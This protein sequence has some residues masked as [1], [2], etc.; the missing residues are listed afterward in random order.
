MARLNLSLLG[1]PQIELDGHPVIT[2]RRKAIAL[3]TYLAVT[4]TIHSR[5]SLAALFWPESDQSRALAYLRRTLWEINQ[6][7][8]D[9][10]LSIDRNTVTLFPGVDSWLDVYEFNDL[11]AGNKR[12][13]WETAVSLYRGDFLAGFTLRDTPDFDEWHYYQMEQL[14]QTMTA[15]LA[16][17][18]TRLAAQ[19]AWETAVP[20]AHR[21][22][23]LDPLHE[24]A[25][26]H[27]MQL[28]AQ[29]NQKAA[30]IRQ[31][32]ICTRTLAEELNVSP[33]EETTALYERIRA[34]H[35]PGDVHGEQNDRGIE[36]SGNKDQATLSAH[37]TPGRNLPTQSTPFVGRQAELNDLRSL[38]VDSMVRLLSL[39]GPGGSG[40]TRLALQIAAQEQDT[41]ADGVY[42][43]PLAA[44]NSPDNLI[45]AIAKSLRLSFFKEG[46]PPQ[47]QL[48]DYL[49]ARHLLLIL[50]NYE[51]LLVDDSGAAQV[52]EI[53]TAAPDVKVL[54]TS[55]L[56]LSLQAEHL[57]M[58]QGMRVPD[59]QA[60][61]DW[62]HTEQTITDFIVPYSAI[63]LFV[64]AA[65]RA[66]PTFVLSADTLTIVARICR[67]LDG[68]PLAI[69]LAAAW[70]S[71]L[72]LA[73]IE[74]E[75]GH[76]LDFLATDIHDVPERQRSIRAV[77]NYS[78]M[79]LTEPEKAVL[80]QLTIFQGGFTREAAQ[81]VANASL[82]M[83][84]AMMH[85]SLIKRE[86]DG[87]F[88]MH[89]LLRQYAAEK[90]QDD[91]EVWITVR[92]R[93]STFY[94]DL[95]RREGRYMQS[96]AQRAGFDAVEQ[97]IENVR[98]AWLWAIVQ[99]QYEAVLPTLD[100]LV[101][102][103]MVRATLI[104]G[105]ADLFDMVLGDLETVVTTHTI[106]PGQPTPAHLLYV[107]ILA[108][109]AW[110]TSDDYA[111][112]IPVALSSKAL[113]LTEKWN[114]ADQIGLPLT[115]VATVYAYRVDK[116]AGI[117]WGYRSLTYLRA[118]DHQWGLAL[119]INMMGSCLH[120]VGVRTGVKELL[121]EGGAISRSIGDDLLLAYNLT[122]LAW[123]LTDERDFSQAL[124]IDQECQTLFE[125]VGDRAGAALNH[126]NL[127][128]VYDV[129]GEYE[130]AA[131][132]YQHSR[133]LFAELGRRIEVANC[134]GWE[135]QMW[136]R[137]GAYEKALTLRQQ[138]LLLFQEIGDDKGIAWGYFELGELNHLLC[139]EDEAEA[140]YQQAFTCFTRLQMNHGLTFF[141]R[142]RGRTRLAAGDVP[143]ARA[144]LEQ[145]IALSKD[146]SEDYWNRAYTLCELAHVALTGKD[147]EMAT[148]RFHEALQLANRW[149]SLG[150]ILVILAG[151][152]H[153]WAY[154]KKYARAAE[155]ATLVLEH[156]A[157]WDETKPLARLP[158]ET[159][160]A[161]MDPTAF[162]E[163]VSRGHHLHLADVVVQLLAA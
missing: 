33:E 55:R 104:P 24:P 56:R 12:E 95:L 100:Y 160:Q 84:I 110:I 3:L 136:Q 116:Q 16:K 48:F 31:Y 45:P 127:A 41:F 105:L 40:K 128:S 68:M 22:L 87:R 67:L 39:I 146:N 142:A 141:Y 53:L 107:K 18:V 149:A 125:Q 115:L 32:E 62:L 77:F 119:A 47:Q 66:Q 118:Q 25:H 156:R 111:S 132:Q 163:A 23:N 35:F 80:P 7:L 36:R 85:K 46:E 147:Y 90:L 134:L 11:A 50:D 108:L 93:H 71:L 15:T 155:I 58:V 117:A 51:H 144:D 152:A 137:L 17:L 49:R 2:D 158:L 65:Q 70:L 159:A 161:H 112:P 130:L 64:V 72:T 99:Q 129:S 97:E 94:I 122:T 6:M 34:G 5:E 123:V 145:S 89:D 1:T 54:V 150:I 148:Q 38:L 42:F 114:I 60:V 162:A 81:R 126:W 120:G 151:F 153:M 13:G 83:L 37:P 121:H 113:Q 102:F 106:Q 19:S 10:W 135:S 63:Q 75:I 109:Q 88:A 20:Y 92:N 139:R 4:G 52:N 73:E 30:A 82:P 69:E 157:T 103:Y 91:P 8:G 74:A 96:A 27:L 140:S 154:E 26:R 29:L 21:W 43:V 59:T 9:G 101:Y 76:N 28:Y 57:Y 124:Q 44:L 133:H 78:W 143:G 131:Q 138:A 86:E 98:A 61:S 79:L 14:R